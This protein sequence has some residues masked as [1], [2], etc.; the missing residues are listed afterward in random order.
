MATLLPASAQVFPLDELLT[1]ESGRSGD[2][3]AMQ[4]PSPARD[5]IE[6]E[7]SGALPDSTAIVPRPGFYRSTAT[8]EPGEHISGGQCNADCRPRTTTDHF[9]S[10]SD[11]VLAL[12]QQHVDALTGLGFHFA[13]R[14]D[15]RIHRI[16]D[17]NGE[18]IAG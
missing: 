3:G 12:V 6:Q 13:C 2:A 11:D 16:G 5:F 15:A 1:Q 10:L 14:I 4:R 7:E 17:A 18:V 8:L 9:T